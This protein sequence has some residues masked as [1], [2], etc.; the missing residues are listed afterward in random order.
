MNL[1]K[2]KQLLEAETPLSRHI[3][4]TH[5]A[6]PNIFETQDGLLG[7]V[8]QVKGVPYLVAEDEDLACHQEIVHRLILQLGSDFMVMETLHRRYEST[9]LSGTFKHDFCQLLHKKYH[10]RFS[11]GV[12]VNDIY[13]T[14]V[15]KGGVKNA[16]KKGVINK[17]IKSSNQLLDKTFIDAKAKQRQ[18]GIK[19]LNLKVN[20]WIT[21][22]SQFGVK[23]LGDNNHEFSDLLKFLSL[24]PNGG[25]PTNIIDAAYF[26]VRAKT[27]NALQNLKL[28]YP[29]GHLGHYLANHRLFFGDAIQFQGNTASDSRFAA[30]LSIKSYDKKTSSK[31]LDA[32]LALD[33]EFIRTQTFA[34]LEQEDAINAIETAHDKKVSAD[35]YAVSQIDELANLADLV[36]SEKVSIGFH[37]NSLMLLSSSKEAL[38][39]AIHEATNAYSKTGIAVVRETLGQAISFFAQIPGNSRFIARAAP[40]TS[41]NQY[42]MGN[43]TAN[44]S[45]SMDAYLKKN[46][47]SLS[48]YLPNTPYLCINDVITRRKYHVGV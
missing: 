29:Q 44:S 43:V 17:L 4:I 22:L 42:T 20:Q 15:Y 2:L 25:N 23:R 11:G 45:Y 21:S 9:T 39:K 18:N 46:R 31:S 33:C 35:D 36:A 1:I 5:L 27:P 14:I 24:I 16:N 47:C 34:P 19:K 12:Y 3:P 48:Q 28:N 6:A 7:A 41:E 10:Q 40:I 37:H 30:M 26:P 32:L 38:D 13:L 8:L